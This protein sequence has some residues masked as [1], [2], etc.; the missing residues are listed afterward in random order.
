[1]V[2]PK[3]VM[4]RK[5]RIG[6]R[7]QLNYLS[8][9]VQKWQ[10]QNIGYASNGSPHLANLAEPLRTTWLSETVIPLLCQCQNKTST[11]ET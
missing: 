7:H 10:W 1:M 11:F 9:F 2:I 8:Y 5:F 3:S 4:S 6:W